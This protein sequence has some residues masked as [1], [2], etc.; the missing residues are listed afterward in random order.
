MKTKTLVK[1]SSRVWF[2]DDNGTFWSRDTTK[3]IDN[4]AF[5]RKYGKLWTGRTN[6]RSQANYP[7]HY[8]EFAGYPTRVSIATDIEKLLA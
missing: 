5:I 6:W 3:R 8:T 7:Y 2:A 1:D 4:G